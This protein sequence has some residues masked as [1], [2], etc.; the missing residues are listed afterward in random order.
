MG[1]RREGVVQDLGVHFAAKTAHRPHVGRQLH[2][3]GVGPI[4]VTAH[5]TVGRVVQVRGPKLAS[6]HTHRLQ[7]VVR[8][9]EH[10]LPQGL[11]RW[12]SG[13]GGHQA[14]PGRPNVRQD[15]QLAFHVLHQGRV[16]LEAFHQGRPGWAVRFAVHD[17]QCVA[18]GPCAGV[19]HDVP[20]VFRSPCK[21]VAVGLVVVAEDQLVLVLRRAHFVE[22]HAVEGVFRT[23]RTAFRRGVAAVVE[24]IVHPRGTRELHPLQHFPRRFT[25]GQIQHAHLLPIRP[26]RVAHLHHVPAVGRS[27]GQACRHR[28]V[29]AQGV[30]VQ[31]H[32]LFSAFVVLNENHTL[33]LQPV[34][35]GQEHLL[36]DAAW[37]ANAWV[38]EQL[39]ATF[40]QLFAAREAV[41]ERRRRLSLVCDPRH[42]LRV[43]VVFQPTVRIGHRGVPQG[44]DHVDSSG[45]RIGH[46]LG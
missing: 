46:G 21:V 2:H 12:Q 41:Q 40:T 11:V 1:E 35:P 10:V 6:H 9:W 39:L 19:E 3:P 13:V 22:V 32:P 29:F 28:A 24:A 14:V 27:S 15:V 45:F 20:S 25:C 7:Q 4:E 18:V 37:N 36:P 44:V 26:C 30:G 43:A 33:V 42:H 34:V 8:L 23:E 17:V 16:V 5:H 38:V 31:E